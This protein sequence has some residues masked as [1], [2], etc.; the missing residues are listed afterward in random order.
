MIQK[1]INNII[2]QRKKMNALL[3]SGIHPLFYYLGRSLS[4]SYV[5]CCSLVIALGLFLSLGSLDFS[6]AFFRMYGDCP[7]WLFIH[8]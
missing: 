1:S 3:G 8:L 4:F 6:F 5:I 2:I 7:F